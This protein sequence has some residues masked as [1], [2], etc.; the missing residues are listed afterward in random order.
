MLVSEA[1]N[2]GTH[3]P[4]ECRWT[5]SMLNPLPEVLVVCDGWRISRTVVWAFSDTY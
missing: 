2:V 1:E 5:N 3:V 4:R